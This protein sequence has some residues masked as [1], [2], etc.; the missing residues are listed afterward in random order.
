VRVVAVHGLTLEVETAEDPPTSPSQ[1]AAN[2][3]GS[4]A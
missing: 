3:P 1:K 4:D 2:P